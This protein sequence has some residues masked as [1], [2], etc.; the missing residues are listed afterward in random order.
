MAKLTASDAAIGD[1]FGLSVSISGRYAIVG[2][3]LNW[4]EPDSGS[5]Y[6]FE[7]SDIAWDQVAKLKASDDAVGDL[8]SADVSISGE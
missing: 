3:N 5:A 6:I 2:A 4:K 1:Y 8:F 7:K